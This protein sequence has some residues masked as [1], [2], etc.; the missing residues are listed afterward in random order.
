MRSLLT[1]Q[2]VASWLRL[3]VAS[4]YS[5]RYRGDPPGSL[6]FS[7]GRYIRFASA[8]IEQWIEDQKEEGGR[9]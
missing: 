3:P 6:G 8:D 7:C 5:Q 9:A 2:E 1:V 4:I